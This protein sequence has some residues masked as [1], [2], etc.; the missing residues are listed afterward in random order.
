M[1]NS[2]SSRLTIDAIDIYPFDIR[3]HEPFRIATMTANSSHNVLIR[4]RTSGGVDGWGEASPLHSITG[5]TQRICIAAAKEIADLILGVNPLEIASLTGLING[6]LP[7][8]T[9]IKSAFDMALYDIASKVAGLPLYR[10]LGGRLRPMET[11]LTIGICDPK[12]VGAKAKAVLSKGFRNIK[13]KLGT[14]FEEDDLRLKNIREAVGPNIALRIDANQAW[15]RAAAIKSLRAFE[16]YD[17]DFCEQPLRGHDVIGLREVGNSVFIT[18]MADEALHSPTDALRLTS[19]DAV[20][21]FNI[22]LAKSGGIY[23]ALQI[24]DI[25]EAGGRKCMVGCM[26]ESR[27]GLSA[28]AHFACACES[29][30]F[31]DLD[32]C[33]EHAEDPIEGGICINEGM[34]ALTNTPGI[35]A[36][37][38][39]DALKRMTKVAD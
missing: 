29:V 6:F 15:D 12:D 34:I 13:V 32:S 18:L 2:E 17:I 24:A 3:M 21:Y 37:P 33:Y 31:Y 23:S 9:T 25:A 30:H 7:H 28:S 10:F 1:S 5:E 36:A 35:G 4:I 14:T 27:L 26:L 38:S 20:P 39:A 16:D 8:N 22:K 19:E 11:D